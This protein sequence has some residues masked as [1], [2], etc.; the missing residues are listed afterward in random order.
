[1]IFQQLNPG[2]CRTY[3]IADEKSQRAEYPT[4]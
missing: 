1:M 2:A 3:L 4:A